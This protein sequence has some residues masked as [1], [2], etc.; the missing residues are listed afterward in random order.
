MNVFYEE[1]G[2]FKVGAILAD[3]D[4]SLQVEAPHG[5]RSK[6]K[7]SAVLL[8][9][10]EPALQSFAGEA[11]HA[12]QE[13]DVDFLWE[14]C[15]TDEFSFDALAREYFGRPPTPLECAALLH[16]L[17]GAPMY[18][19]KKGKGR[20]KAAP[21]DALKAA[22]ASVEKKR[23]QAEQ[24]EQWRD[25]LVA[26][27]LPHE[28]AP[29]VNHLLYA[30]DKNRIEWKAL[31]A[32]SEQMKMA[33]ARVL[34]QCG[35]LASAHDYHLNRFLFEYFPQGTRDMYAAAVATPADLPRAGVKA[36][37]I[38]DATTTEIDDAFSVTRLGNGNTQI[39]IHIAAP[40]L[41]VSTGSA[42][43]AIAR[44]RLSTVYFPGRK[45]TMLPEAVVAAYTLGEGQERPALSLY[46]EVAADMSIVATRTVA[47]SVLIEANLRHGE[48][49]Q[50]FNERTLESGDVAHA[51]GGELQI[52]WRFAQY[53]Q[54]A[55]GKAD[56]AE[57]QRTEYNFYVADERIEIVERLRG[58]PVDKIVSELMIYAN[59]EWGGQLA[60]AEYPAIYR[61][62]SNGTAR[63]TTAPSRHDGLGVAQYAWSSSPL[64]R[65][66]DL[67][68]QRQLLALVGGQAPVYRP[69]DESL[70]AALRDFEVA[71]D[72]YAEFQR[73]ME[74]YWC[75]RWIEQENAWVQTATVLRDN[76][77]RFNRLPIVMRVPSLHDV[78][79]G[80][81][82][83]L[84]IS[85]VDL[86]ELSLH[87]E[88][89]SLVSVF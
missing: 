87:A 82:V 65:Y 43:D 55:R 73:N 79:S 66:V 51:L 18:F 48:L 54:I 16:K 67:I 36:F 14:C 84:A 63:M 23:L 77:V 5:K 8:R 78:K 38:D 10:G 19:Y 39:G 30:P 2:T 68:N 74:R 47:E 20:Y 50:L 21:A 83:S 62:Q 7:S 52:L 71:Y 86:W 60:K 81:Q 12:A 31:E 15:G 57:N 17:H 35:A 58:S 11:Q 4:T 75:L 6:V 88:F 85:K 59:A 46:V 34:V 41:G 37:S 32:A 29:L 69:S 40:A 1:E 27:R 76:L 45:I 25:E 28:F 26:G 53:L 49:E 13:I 3:N 33:P 22:L 24:K 9:F 56:E 42:L 64:R 72:A 70:L 61:A 44:Q 89:E 80:D